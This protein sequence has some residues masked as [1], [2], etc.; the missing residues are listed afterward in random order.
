MGK[1]EAP[2]PN[3][4]KGRCPIAPGVVWA[5]DFT[6]IPFHG[7]FLFLATVL[8]VFTREVLGWHILSVHTAALIHGAFEDVRKRAHKLPMYHHSDQGSEYKELKHLKNVERL[9]ITVSMSKKGSLWENGYQES[10]YSQFKLEIGGSNRFESEG[11]LIEEIY[12]LIYRY[13]TTRIH[14]SLKMS[15]QK[16]AQQFYEKSALQ[17]SERV[18]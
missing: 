1:P 17:S 7:T 9:G 15:P 16:F 5:T 18:S 13:N 6:Y 14:T 8:D 11:E 2:Y 4:I 10:Y 3:F 12:R